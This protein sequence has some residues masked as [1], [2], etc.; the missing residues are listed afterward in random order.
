MILFASNG[1]TPVAPLTGEAGTTIIA[2][3]NPTRAGYVFNGWIPAL[4]EKMPED[5]LAVAAQW[6]LAVS[7]G[8]KNLKYYVSPNALIVAALRDL[9]PIAHQHY[10]GSAAEYAVFR[11]TNRIATIRGS[12]KN[13]E[14]TVMGYVDVISD[15]YLSGAN[16]IVNDIEDALISAGVILTDI[17]DGGY[18]PEA[19]RFH[20]ELSI[21]VPMEVAHGS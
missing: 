13:D 14:V 5:D 11:W 8:S 10:P 3:I 1:G 17:Y 4:P 21:T 6:K 7:T 15:Q 18:D 12:G 9:I 16:S 20:M 19:N 2:P